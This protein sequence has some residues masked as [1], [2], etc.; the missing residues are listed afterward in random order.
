MQ[1]DD[2]FFKHVR[3]FLTVYLPKNKCFSPHTIKAYRDTLNLFRKFLS[4]TKG[5]AFTAIRFDQINHQVVYDFLSWLQTTRGCAVATKN[6]RLAVLKS[7][8]H[9]CAMEDPALVA[10]YLDL[11]KIRSQRVVRNRVDYLSEIALKV[12]LQQPDPTTRMG[13]RDRMLMILL[14]DSGAR[15]QELLDLQLR[16]LHLEEQTP[17]LYL[18]GKGQKTR[19]VPLMEKTIAHLQ[20]YLKRYLPDA[21]TQMDQYLFYTRIKGRTGKMSPDNVACFLKRYAQ[22][23]HP[24]CS[25]VPLRIHAH[26]FRHTRA[27]H[28]Y[29]AGIPLSYIKDFLGHVSVNT[30]DIYASTDISMMKAALEKISQRADGQAAEEAPIWQDN[31]ELILQLCGLK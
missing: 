13:M 12:L 14:Y 26:L 21:K 15:I 25:A 23:A 10:H 17:C 31:E 3:G 29:Q 4:E 19:A 1:P 9:Y 24:V 22:M 7:F 27:M 18:T 5:L 20:E 30:T 16:D 8:F 6:L 2:S 28:L 11:Q